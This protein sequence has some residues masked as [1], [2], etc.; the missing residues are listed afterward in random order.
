MSCRSAATSAPW[1]NAAVL[2]RGVVAAVAGTVGRVPEDTLVI[3][4]SAPFF[5]DPEVPVFRIPLGSLR[6]AGGALRRSLCAVIP[7]SAE[8]G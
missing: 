7:L 1:E 8:R 2:Q 4:Y 6:G 3:T 5:T